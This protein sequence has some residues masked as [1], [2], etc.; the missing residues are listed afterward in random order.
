VSDT[1]EDVGSE[2]F[3]SGDHVASVLVGIASQPHRLKDVSECAT[4]ITSLTYGTYDKKD[5]T[6]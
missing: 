6:A 4:V 5:P 2:R 1:F 3:D